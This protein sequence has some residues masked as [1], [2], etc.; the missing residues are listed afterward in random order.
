MS[1]NHNLYE[2][3]TTK[4]G[5][6]MPFGVWANNKT[7]ASKFAKSKLRRGERIISLERSYF[8]KGYKVR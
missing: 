8:P 5:F 1:K 2:L 7:A 4:S 6:D 3:T